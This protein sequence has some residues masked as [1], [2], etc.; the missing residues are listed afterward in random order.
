VNES[1]AQLQLTPSTR[2]ETD[3][4]TLDQCWIE[5]KLAMTPWER[6]RAHGRALNMAWI[7]REA[8]EKHDAG[9]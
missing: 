9:L 3:Q 8:M 1:E 4:S 6:I 2:E 5:E 7:L